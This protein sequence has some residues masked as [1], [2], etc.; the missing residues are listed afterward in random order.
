MSRPVR[1]Q[2]GSFWFSNRPDKHKVRGRC[3]LVSY[4]VSMKSV[5]SCREEVEKCIGQSEARAAIFD[6]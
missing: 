1:G 2:G 6:F 5:Q 3:D 4:Q